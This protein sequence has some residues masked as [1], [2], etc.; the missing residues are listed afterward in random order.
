MR[1]LLKS[2]LVLSSVRNKV[3]KQIVEWWTITVCLSTEALYQMICNVVF[4]LTP[5]VFSFH[6]IL[7]FY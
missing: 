6:L 1:M 3:Y 5:F 4:S 7:T 2:R